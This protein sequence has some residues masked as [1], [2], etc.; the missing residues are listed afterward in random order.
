[1]RIRWLAAGVVALCACT[2]AGTSPYGRTTHVTGTVVAALSVYLTG[3]VQ[4]TVR[5]GSGPGDTATRRQ[6]P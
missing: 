1:V 5:T 2:D 4:I 6:V 3:P